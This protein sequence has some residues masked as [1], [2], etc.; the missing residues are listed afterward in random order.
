MMK[1]GLELRFILIKRRAV[2]ALYITCTPKTVYISA[3]ILREIF[4]RSAL[5]LIFVTP[6]TV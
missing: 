4:Q 5:H 6:S 2:G 1:V 3:N